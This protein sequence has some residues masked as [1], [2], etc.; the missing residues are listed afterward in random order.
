M[1]LEEEFSQ[2]VEEWNAHIEY[3]RRSF[4]D[5]D[6]INCDAYR[7]LAS[8]GKNILPLIK[9]D[10]DN[11]RI[12]ERSFDYPGYFWSYVLHEIADFR[13]EMGE[14]GSGSPIE[15]KGGKGGFVSVNRGMVINYMKD[16]LDKN[17]TQ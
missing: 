8:M 9:R 2:T 15:R 7:K 13:I 6:Y 17:I 4:S 16:W 12:T 3:N 5:R 10:L 11:C 1:S 14:E